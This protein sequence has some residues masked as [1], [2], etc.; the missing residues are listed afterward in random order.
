MVLVLPK[1]ADGI[2]EPQRPLCLGRCE[3]LRSFANQTPDR[4]FLSRQTSAQIKLS[5]GSMWARFLTRKHSDTV[6]VSAASGCT[7]SRT[8]FF[9]PISGSGNG[10]SAGPRHHEHAA[11]VMANS[12]MEWESSGWDFSWLVVTGRCPELSWWCGHGFRPTSRRAKA[13]CLPDVLALMRRIWR[14]N[15]RTGRRPRLGLR[16]GRQ[17]SAQA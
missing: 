17:A 11:H 7:Q 16:Q 4:E 2:E 10:H 5:A 15:R 9:Q 8:H 14:A 1:R 3:R 13:L 12:R 6:A